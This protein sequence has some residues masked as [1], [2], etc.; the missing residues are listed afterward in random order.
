MKEHDSDE[1]DVIQQD[2]LD[3]N[4]DPAESRAAWA[5][6]KSPS[7]ARGIAQT[8]AWILFGWSIVYLIVG[9]LFISKRSHQSIGVGLSYLVMAIVLFFL[10][11]K[12]NRFSC[13]A[14][15]MGL[16]I[17]SISATLAIIKGVPGAIFP[18]MS[19]AFLIRPL[20]AVYALRRFDGSGSK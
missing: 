3:S 12:L 20:R 2:I 18:T 13:L 14:A 16:L 19:A 5:R 8:G 1:K 6:I 15:W 17:L 7:H 9:I 4:W 10:G 11:R